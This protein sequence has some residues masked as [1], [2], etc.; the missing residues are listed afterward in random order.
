VVWKNIKKR[1]HTILNHLPFPILEL[2]YRHDHIRNVAKEKT[3]INTTSENVVIVFLDLN[4]DANRRAV[5][6][7]AELWEENRNKIWVQVLW[8][9]KF[10][11]S[12]IQEDHIRKIWL[13]GI[14]LIYITQVNSSSGKYNCCDFILH[15]WYLLR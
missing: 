2:L 4:V 3:R 6:W 13:L 1:I 5:H 9:V 10:F 7:K 11:H 8:K 12:Y 15:S 14:I